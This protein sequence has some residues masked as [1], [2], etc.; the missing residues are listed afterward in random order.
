MRKYLGILL[1]SIPGLVYAL[2]D[3]NLSWKCTIVDSNNVSWS[4]ESIYKRKA[5]NTLFDSC[6]NKSKVPA[7]CIM[8]NISC[9]SFFI[10]R[11]STT[12]FWQCMALDSN[13][14]A[15]FGNFSSQRDGAALSA[16]RKCTRNSI[17]P[18]TCY[19]HMLTCRNRNE[20]R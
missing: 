10:N 4:N 7:S 19:I 2:L 1:L 20:V 15:W 12:P 13:A 9:A 3:S 14:S 18:A 5:V 6:K 16:K 11:T 8:E 17:I